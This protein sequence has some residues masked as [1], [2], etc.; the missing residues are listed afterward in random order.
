MDKPAD[1]AGDELLDD[2]NDELEAARG[3]DSDDDVM[4]GII[5]AAGNEYRK[6]GGG[7]N[8]PITPRLG[9]F[10]PQMSSEKEKLEADE[11]A[12]KL[13]DDTEPIV[14]FNDEIQE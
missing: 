6:V 5:D 7:P 10:L 4:G 11:D 14:Y 13:E 8:E 2:L 12:E 1:G 9:L 3:K